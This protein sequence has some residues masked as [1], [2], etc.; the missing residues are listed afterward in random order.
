[1]KPSNTL[2]QADRLSSLRYHVEPWD[3]QRFFFFFMAYDVY[4]YL[5][6]F[7]NLRI[8]AQIE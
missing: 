8:N 2:F 3:T 1:M 6:G 5:Y 7:D 4:L